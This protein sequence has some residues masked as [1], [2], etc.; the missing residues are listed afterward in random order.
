VKVKVDGVQTTGGQELVV[1]SAVITYA[2]VSAEGKELRCH[3]ELAHLGAQTQR[4]RLDDC[5]RAYVGARRVLMIQRRS[6]SVRK[7]LN[8]S[9]H[10]NA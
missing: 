8:V 6:F 5:S 7:R 10:G 9:H 2:G 4:K 1:V 3:A